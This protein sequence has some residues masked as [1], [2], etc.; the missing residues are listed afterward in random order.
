MGLES[1]LPSSLSSLYWFLSWARSIRSIPHHSISPRSILILS[2][3]LRFG[4]PSGLFPSNFPI[5]ISLLSHASY[6]LILLDLTAVVTLGGGYTLWRATFCN[7]IPLRSK[8]LSRYTPRVAEEKHK[9]PQVIFLVS[10]LRSK[11]RISRI[12]SKGAIGPNT[13]F[14]MALIV[15]D[16]ALVFNLGYAKTSYMNQNET[17]EQLKNSTSSDLR[18]LEDSSPI[19]GADMPETSSIISLTGQNHINNW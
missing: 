19:W 4:L 1:S 16:R 17:Q 12:Q 10:W 2:T 14:S 5:C 13:T 15:S 11:P 18:T 3:H 9:E 6:S 8:M 7:L